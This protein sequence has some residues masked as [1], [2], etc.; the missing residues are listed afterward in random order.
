MQGNN[1]M[2]DNDD[3]Q[4]NKVR[5]VT[6]KFQQYQQDMY[7][8]FTDD[9][10]VNQT[11]NNWIRSEDGDPILYRFMMLPKGK[12]IDFVNRCILAGY[13]NGPPADSKLGLVFQIFDQEND[14]MFIGYN[15][16]EY[17]H[18]MWDLLH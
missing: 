9:D 15:D 5:A 13:I 18:G 6:N 14:H 4:I 12:L 17:P 8:P 3:S 10:I 11:L 2:N 1:M 16:R 7:Y